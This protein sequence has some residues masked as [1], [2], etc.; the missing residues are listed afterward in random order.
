MKS[1]FGYQF[2]K[3]IS[4]HCVAVDNSA[5]YMISRF[6]V[7]V[8]SEAEPSVLCQVCWMGIF[9]LPNYEPI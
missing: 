4:A 1:H 5:K 8:K 9:L 6:F 3:G 2:Y 7:I